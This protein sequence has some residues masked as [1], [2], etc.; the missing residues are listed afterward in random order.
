MLRGDEQPPPSLAGAVDVVAVGDVACDAREEPDDHECL[1]AQT[2]R[3]AQG[4]DPDA[5]LL[6]GDIQYEEGTVEQY[7]TDG[8]YTGTWS[9][10]TDR[11]WP[12]PG[13]HEWRTEG[14]AGYRRVF[15]ARTGGERWYSRDIGAW[16]VVSL[17]T[18]CQDVGGCREQ[19]DWL[20][21]DL[22]SADGRP[23][24]VFGHRPR[25]SSGR[26]GDEDELDAIWRTVAADRD[27]QLVLSSHNHAYER[28][29]PRSVDGEAADDGLTSF[30]VGTGGH[31]LYCER[32]EGDVEPEAYGCESFGVLRLQLAPQ[33]WSWEFVSSTGDLEDSGT[34]RLR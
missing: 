28:F 25:W 32:T 15:D 11:T 23:T 26:Y 6:L 33:A 9:A 14:A 7:T 24:V 29:P 18:E 1:H 31:S 5:V 27:V 13:N 21:R 20:R 34:R 4:L 12:A 16:H 2:A 22:A 30:V 3:T 8:G 17:D 19:Q 10:L